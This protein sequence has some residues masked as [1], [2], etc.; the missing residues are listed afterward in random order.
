MVKKGNKKYGIKKIKT[1]I[2]IILFIV[3][4]SKKSNAYS[5]GCL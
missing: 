5:E 4:S 3:L 2:I 1:N